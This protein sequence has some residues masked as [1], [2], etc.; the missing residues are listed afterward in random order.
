MN[1]RTGIDITHT[2]ICKTDSKWEVAVQHMELSSVLCDDLDMWGM[3]EA[4]EEGEMY[5]YTHIQLIHF[6]AQ[7]KLT[8]HLAPTVHQYINF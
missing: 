7:Q 6:I 8:E 2:T 5:M 1:W 3:R 4:Q